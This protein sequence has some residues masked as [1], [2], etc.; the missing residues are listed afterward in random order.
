MIAADV[1]G[2]V[3]RVF[4]DFGTSFEVLDADGEE[5]AELLLKSVSVLKERSVEG[6]SLL[7][8]EFLPKE[9]PAFAVGDLL[10]LGDVRPFNEALG[11]D[12]SSVVCRVV[13]GEKAQQGTIAKILAIKD[14]IYFYNTLLVH[15]YIT[16]KVYRSNNFLHYLVLIKKNCINDAVI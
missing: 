5:P 4:C 10:R 16:Y 8:I 6:K 1:L 14:L 12:F 7:H 13:A 2:L 11:S 9:R 3:G 15:K